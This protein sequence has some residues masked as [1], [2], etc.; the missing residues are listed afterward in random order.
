VE[1]SDT[2]VEK[3]G[4]IILDKTLIVNSNTEENFTTEPL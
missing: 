1:E 4:R 2:K 3:I